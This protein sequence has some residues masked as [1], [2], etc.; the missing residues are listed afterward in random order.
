MLAVM[1]LV[2]CNVILSVS[3]Q[4]SITK[5]VPFTTESMPAICLFGQCKTS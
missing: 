2:A 5:S 1:V 4:D 3:S